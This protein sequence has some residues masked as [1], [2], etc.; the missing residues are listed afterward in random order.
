MLHGVFLNMEGFE[1]SEA[2]QLLPAARDF[3]DLLG[4]GYPHQA[5]LTLVGNR[6]QLSWAAR[7]ILSEGYSTRPR[8]LDV[9]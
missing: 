8:R 1:G 6:Y 2:A 7:Q 9:G 5:S 3:R 4:K